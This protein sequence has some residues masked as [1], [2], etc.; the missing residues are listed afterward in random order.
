LEEEL[1][2]DAIDQAIALGFRGGVCLQYYN[3]PL[4]DERLP[5]I[6]HKVRSYPEL[7]TVHLNTNGDYITPELAAE[8]DGALDYMICTLYMNDPIKS[9]RAAWIPTLFKETEVRMKTD[10]HHIPTHFT[11]A[12]D[13]ESLIKVAQGMSCDQPTIRVIINHRRQYLLCCEDVIGNFDLGTFPDVG[14]EDHWLGR[15]NELSNALSVAG[16]RKVHS[17]CMICPYGARP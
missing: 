5:E 1:I 16:G 11:P 3:E 2:Y 13:L 14:I 9:E 7:K 17:Y 8:L 10:S 15:H 6:A 4:M 12:Y